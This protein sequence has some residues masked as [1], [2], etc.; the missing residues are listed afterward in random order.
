MSIYNDLTGLRWLRKYFIGRGRHAYLGLGSWAGCTAVLHAA[1]SPE[2]IQPSS[3]RSSDPNEALAFAARFLPHV[4]GPLLV[5]R[6]Q[7]IRSEFLDI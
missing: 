2:S 5:R 1:S 7:N 3:A 4:I 6:T